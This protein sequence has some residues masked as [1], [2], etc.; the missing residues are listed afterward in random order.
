MQTILQITLI[1]NVHD[2]SLGMQLNAHHTRCD[3]SRL[4][5]KTEEMFYFCFVFKMQEHRLH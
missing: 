1:L 4:S 2:T 3:V 5:V